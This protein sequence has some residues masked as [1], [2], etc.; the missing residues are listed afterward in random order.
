MFFCFGLNAQNIQDSIILKVKLQFDSLE[1]KTNKE[2]ISFQKDTMS[3]ESI[4]FYL[5]NFQFIYKDKSI[6]K[7]TNSYHLIDFDEPESMH[8][9]FNKQKDKQIESIQF[10]IGVDSLASVSGALE[11]DLDATKGMYWVW[12]SGF[13]NMKIEGNSPSCNT[14]K[15]KFQFHIGGYLKPYYAMRTIKVPIEKI[16][17]PNREFNLI[18]DLGKLFS[19]ISLKDTNTIMIPGKEA[20]KNADLSTKIF[21]IK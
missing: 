2:Y 21:S 1:F 11:G 5:T 12:Q 13:I 3:F 7:E 4:R 8:L 14:R 19:E 16:E 10:N 6:Y 17:I 20:M 18:M 15:N 9:T